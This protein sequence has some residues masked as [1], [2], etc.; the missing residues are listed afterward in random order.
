[1]LCSSVAFAIIRRHDV[2]DAEYTVEA[3][4]YPA[5]AD[6]LEPGDCLATL[7]TSRWALTA[8]HCVQH[9]EL[10]RTLTFGDES[11][12]VAGFV[13]NPRF[14][15]LRHDIALVHLQ[16][17]V[18]VEPV[19]I[20]RNRDELGRVVTLVG[21]GDTATGLE[22]QAGARLDL[23]TRRATNTVDEVTSR[24]LKFVFH[25]PEDEMATALEGISG[26]G[27]SGG[28][29]FIDG[30]EGQQ[31][32]GLSAFQDAPNS[33]L[34]TYGVT[35]VYTRVSSYQD[36]VDEV[37]APGWDG[38]YRRCDTCSTS[39]VGRGGSSPWWV[40]AVLVLWYRR[41]TN[42]QRSS[43]PKNASTRSSA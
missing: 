22:G 19:G 25:A 15:G 29:A 10:P 9:L 20:Y 12:A 2:E 27:D 41:S 13:C 33:R 4:D 1:M 14:D 39:I 26:D 34:G 3:T 32:A 17:A 5:V 16:E 23:Q 40:A 18:S 21:R 38:R 11:A 35:E 7:I 8:A 42:R 28:P 43:S 6:L 30:P 24:W 31:L 36:F 37:T